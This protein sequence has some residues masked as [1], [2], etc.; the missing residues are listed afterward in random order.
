VTASV[1]G[2]RRELPAGTTLGALVDQLAGRRA[3]VAVALN[4]QVVPRA[5]WDV[6]LVG[7]DDQVELLSA[8][9]GG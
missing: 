3:G 5:A 7:P 6:T 4:R 2:Q 1:N 9:A 8:V